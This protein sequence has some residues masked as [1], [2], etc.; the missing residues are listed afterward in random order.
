MID[1]L[2]GFELAL[3]PTFREDFREYE[4]TSHG[5]VIGP[6]FAQYRGL[7][8]G[9]PERRLPP[10]PAF[11]GL[12]EQEVTVLRALRSSHWEWLPGH[13]WSVRAGGIARLAQSR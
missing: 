6:S 3:A 5:M 2:S 1:S 12:S 4:I 7:I 9:V 11:P 13:D 10:V 8:T